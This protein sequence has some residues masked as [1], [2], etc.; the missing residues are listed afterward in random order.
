MTFDKTLFDETSF[1]E[2]SFD[3]KTWYLSVT[4]YLQQCREVIVQFL[5]PELFEVGKSPVIDSL[6]NFRFDSRVR[7]Y[8]I[9]KKFHMG[10]I[11]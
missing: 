6:V 10:F 2:M 7:C 11:T 9:V 1:D 4:N 5:K 3:E 8:K